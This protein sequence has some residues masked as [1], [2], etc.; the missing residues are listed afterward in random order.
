MPST[1]TVFLSYRRQPSADIARLIRDHLVAKGVDVFFDV[2]SINGGGRLP[3]VIEHAIIERSHFII[4]LAPSTLTAEWVWREAETARRYNKPV[5]PIETDGFNW[6]TDVPNGMEW[7]KDIAGISYDYKF[8]EQAFARI[9]RALR[10][11]QYRKRNLPVPLLLGMVILIT[12]LIIG[13]SKLVPTEAS[14]NTPDSTIALVS[15]ELE[16]QP[17][18]LPTESATPTCIGTIVITTGENVLLNQV[19]A[20]RQASAPTRPP[21]RQGQAVEI[22]T[23]ELG[24][25]GNWYQIQYGDNANTGWIPVNYV[26]LIEDCSL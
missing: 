15:P 1:P 18:V 20:F 16:S 25:G 23:Q 19:R 10:L 6:S 17:T 9:E 8:T 14:P 3:E 2:D 21:V 24:E 4:I 13:A 26:Q 11:E 7:L 5:I 12:I 22:L